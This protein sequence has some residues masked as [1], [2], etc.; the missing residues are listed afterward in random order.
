MTITQDEI[1][2]KIQEH[3]GKEITQFVLKWKGAVNYAYYIE[4]Q[5]GSKYVAKQEKEIKEFQPQNDLVVEAKVAKQLYDLNLSV[6]IPKVVFVSEDPKMY[7]YEYVEGDL[8][9][10]VWGLLS[11]DEKISVCR[12]LGS[13]HAEIGKKFTKEMV[14]T[15]GITI[16]MSPDLHPEVAADYNRLIIDVNVPEHF[17]TLAQEAKLIFDRTQ[18]KLVFQFLHNDSHHE[19][20]IIKDKMISGII[21]F[22][23]SEYGETAKE[24]S[25]YIRDFPDYFQYIVSSYEEQSG[26]KLSYQRL[27][28]NALLSGFIDIVESYQKGGDDRVQAENAIEK[29]RFLLTKKYL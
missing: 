26:N 17:K 2:L 10:N 3:L 27:V 1:K 13:F 5:D 4:T 16:D 11:E 28:S 15:I 14:E 24:F 23:N 8:M 6:P 18:D 7:G 9:R 21:D 22:G 29:Y 12:K 25:R 20:I 19:N